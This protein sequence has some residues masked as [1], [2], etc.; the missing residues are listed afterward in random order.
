MARA[1]APPMDAEGRS[2]ATAP[3]AT[4]TAKPSGMLCRVM[5]ST[6]RVLRCH[7]VLMPSLCDM[8]KPGWRWGRILSIRRI[9]TPP[10]MKPMAAVNQGMWPICSAISM[11]GAS[12]DQKLAAIITPAAKP[13][14]ASRSR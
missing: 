1:M 8:A 13:S 4:P 3:K 12:S 14:R 10:P 5:A 6:S 11:P 2:A 9:K 7:E